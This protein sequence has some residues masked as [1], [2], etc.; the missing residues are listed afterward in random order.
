ML[1]L[2][3]RVDNTES[4]I[5]DLVQ[6]LLNEYVEEDVHTKA[7]DVP[8][9]TVSKLIVDELYQA[10]PAHYKIFCQILIC[11]RPVHR[12]K[13]IQ[14]QFADEQL[15]IVLNENWQNKN[16]H[17]SVHLFCLYCV[18]TPGRLL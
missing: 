7:D 4:I 17:I 14:R 10:L 12:S 3:N 16:F 9:D 1:N 5:R 2:R 8:I 15:D 6:D 11:E 13:M 18:S